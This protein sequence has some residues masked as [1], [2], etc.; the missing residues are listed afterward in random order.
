MDVGDEGSP[1]LLEKHGRPTNSTIVV[2]LAKHARDPAVVEMLRIATED[3][4]KLSFFS[5]DAMHILVHTLLSQGRFD[6]LPD[7]EDAK[8]WGCVINYVYLLRDRASIEKKRA[9][10]AKMKTTKATNKAVAEKTG[11]RKA[12][13]VVVAEVDDKKRQRIEANEQKK[14]MATNH[15]TDKKA[16]WEHIIADAFKDHD[17][18][19]QS[20]MHSNQ[21]EAMA[22]L[23][24]TNCKNFDDYNITRAHVKRYLGAKYALYKGGTNELARHVLS[25]TPLNFTKIYS[26][27][28]NKAHSDAWL[29]GLI[30]READN[31]RGVV[32]D[33]ATSRTLLVYRFN[34]MKAIDDAEARKTA[35]DKVRKA[36]QD[37]AR[38]AAQEIDRAE[39]RKTAPGAAEDADDL[40]SPKRISLIPSHACGGANYAHITGNWMHA[41]LPNIK[42][43]H[44]VFYAFAKGEDNEVAMI[45]SV[46]AEAAAD[47][48]EEKKNLVVPTK[49]LSFYF[50]GLRKLKTPARWVLGGSVRTN[51]VEL[52]V[53]F[54]ANKR[55][56]KDGRPLSNKY[57]PRIDRIDPT[58]DW[59]VPVWPHTM[60][61]DYTKI[62]GVDKGHHMMYNAARYT[63]EYDR[64]T[65]QPVVEFRRVKKTWYDRASGRVAKNHK[66]KRLVRTAQKKGLMDDITMHT[67]KTANTSA[68]HHAIHARRDGFVALYSV[69]KNKK[70]KR[71]KFAMR[72]REEAVIDKI[73][74]YITWGGNVV[75]AIGDCSKTTGF[76]G[77]SPGGPL[78]KI[79]RR[80]VKRGFSTFEVDESYTSKASVCCHGA[81][82][83]CQ[84]N[85]Q[86]PRTYKIKTSEKN[87]KIQEKK[88]K[89]L[90]STGKTCKTPY[91]KREIHG[92]LICNKCGNT[93]DR[94]V[95]GAVNIA[96]VA[97]AQLY[98]FA[99]PERFTKTLGKEEYTGRVDAHS[100]FIPCQSTTQGVAWCRSA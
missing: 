53:I 78:K 44:P 18:A 47:A 50:E 25:K 82:N 32:G 91:Y 49:K 97:I 19:L 52:Q 93:W 58:K 89:A 7:V 29:R 56:M 83:E 13:Q 40:Q 42:V 86:D 63:G 26:K 38:K 61:T 2:S 73:I 43:T 59:D 17:L 75:P 14:V 27:E 81:K 11:K 51:G 79:E 85:G 35:Q 70:A 22:A 6:E 98:G 10:A 12:D 69:F 28:L 95:V 31:Y 92:I 88:K 1:M 94:D 87:K 3:W 24:A 36:A 41:L 15:R 57:V 23:E 90:E 34:L 60:P 68:F 48:E 55:Y 5:N 8:D 80:M 64:A 46:N 72:Q 62:A 96:D 30:A 45:N 20:T 66:S 100:G 54:E 76:Q 65:G 33:E 74:R 99:R 37:K 4:D 21:F 67:L 16:T 39:V 77:L 84:K 9:A 71:L